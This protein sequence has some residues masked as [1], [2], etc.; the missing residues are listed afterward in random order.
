MIRSLTFAIL[1][2][3]LDTLHAATVTINP[4]M[5]EMRRAGYS[6]KPGDVIIVKSGMI[7]GNKSGR[8][9]RG[10]TVIAKGE[11]DKPIVIKAQ[12]IGKSVLQYPLEL[13][14]EHVVLEG[15]SFK[16]QGCLVING[17]NVRI[18]RCI[19]DDSQA[20]RWLYVHPWCKA[21]EIDHCLFQNKTINR[22]IKKNGNVVSI[23]VRN[24][25]EKHHVHHNHF[26]NIP[27]GGGNNF[28]SLQLM[29]ER[30][31]EAEFDNPQG[32]QSVVEYNLFEECHGEGELISLK[33]HRNIIRHNT[34][35]HNGGYIKTR[36]AQNCIIDGNFFFGK[37]IPGIRW[38]DAIQLLGDGHIITNNYFHGF[39]R[40]LLIFAGTDPGWKPVFNCVFA[41]NSFINNLTHVDMGTGRTGPGNFQNPRDSVFANNVFLGGG[42]PISPSAYP[43]KNFKWSNNFV[44]G[45]S[46]PVQKEYAK[47]LLSDELHLHTVDKTLYLPASQTRKAPMAKG[48]TKDIVGARRSQQTTIGAM[49]YSRALG[50]YRPLTAEDVGPHANLSSK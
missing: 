41:N 23:R 2:F 20:G 25:R 42:H 5:R 44:S 22:K 48:V 49:Q 43:A 37:K 24:Q 21:V 50:K 15:F 9:M 32:T 33:S 46:E 35:I 27:P 26:R 34:F 39:N 11:P 14:G 8:H 4:E 47:W 29:T 16:H 7:A 1:V 17:S 6:V 40:A 3:T 45:N 19:W 30:G 31:R 28:E 12:E 36:W 13:T 38:N 10:I 18:T